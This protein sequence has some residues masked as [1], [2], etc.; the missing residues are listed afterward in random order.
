M[1]QMGCVVLIGV[2]VNNAIVLVDM[3][4]RFGAEGL[5]RRMAIVEAATGRF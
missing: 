5:D 4:N 2:V 1:A 3:V